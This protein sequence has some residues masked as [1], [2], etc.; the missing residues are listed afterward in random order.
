MV[1]S[2]LSEEQQEDAARMYGERELSLS[3]IATRLGLE[4]NQRSAINAAA[5]KFGVPSR[6]G[7]HRGENSGSI[8]FRVY[9]PKLCANPNC[10]VEFK[11]SNSMQ[12]F[13]SP[14]GEENAKGNLKPLRQCDGPDCDAMISGK[15]GRKFCSV[16]C[17]KNAGVYKERKKRTPKYSPAAIIAMA[18]GGKSAIEISE[19]VGCHMSH[20]HRICRAEGIKL[21]PT[22]GAGASKGH[23]VHDPERIIRLIKENRTSRSIAIM[24]KCSQGTVLRIARENGLE[25]RD[26]RT[27]PEKEKILE[28]FSLGYSVSAIAEALACPLRFVN[29]T[30]GYSRRTRTEIWEDGRI[31]TAQ[32]ACSG[33]KL[34][35][36][37]FGHHAGGPHQ[38]TAQ[39]KAC[40]FAKY[41]ERT[42]NITYAAWLAF[43]E[44]GC[45]YCGEPFTLEE[46]VHTDHNHS[47][48]PSKDY[49]CGKC[50]RGIAHPICNQMEGMAMAYPDR[51][52]KIAET[53]L[54][55]MASSS[56]RL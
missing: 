42:Y 23:P 21:A 26:S 41:V 54:S 44:A 28:F 6:R 13:C 17:R 9:V 52:A 14:C 2:L 7:Y 34:P 3:Q 24:I 47:C 15:H 19:T 27:A 30:L 49:S 20:V 4:P 45:I 55:R 53:I 11:P 37:S 8:R 33:E 35:W 46:K 39:C 31:C 18:R 25:V 51:F 40:S 1:R 43:R 5:I 32:I 16:D 36:D 22:S 38:R 48:C 10:R 56:L 29:Q 12:K 50:V